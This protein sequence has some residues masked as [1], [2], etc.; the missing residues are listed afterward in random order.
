MPSLS[1]A[2]PVE[3]VRTGDEARVI[4][5]IDHLMPVL[6][7]WR[8]AEDL[9]NR[10]P[11]VERDL[12]ASHAK[13]NGD[14]QQVMA[15]RAEQQ[16]VFSKFGSFGNMPYAGM[17]AAIVLS[18]LYFAKPGNTILLIF[19][20]L[21]L[22]GGIAWGFFRA[23]GIQ[24]GFGAR[25]MALESEIAN[26]F[27]EIESLTKLKA[28]VE[29]GIEARSGG[30]PEV[31]VANVRFNLA[32]ATIDGRNVLLDT[33]GDT[34]PTV[35]RAVD[36]SSMQQG[37]SGI[38]AKAEAL[39]SVPPMLAPGQ[40][41]ES[42]D[43]V[44]QLF[45]EERELQDLVT[46]FTFGLGKLK[47]VSLSL[48]MLTADGLLVT[49]LASPDPQKAGIRSPEDGPAIEISKGSDMASQIQSFVQGVNQTKQ[50]GNQVFS[51]MQEVFR[52]LELACSIYANAR[53]TSVNTVHQNL[54]EVLNRATWCG[55]RFYCPRTILSP[56]YLQDILEIDPAKAFLLSL[57]DL[58]MRLRRDPEVKRRLD[59]SP[60]LEEQLTAA[61]D[62][63]QSFIGDD[64]FDEHGQRTS[65]HR[66]PK[67][68]ED[69][70]RESVKLFSSVLTRVMTGSSYPILNFSTE[71][72]VFY[73][74][75]ME[76]WRSDVVP[77]T[78][79]TP[80]IQKYGGV[81]KA[82]SDLLLPLWE[83][84]WT[85]KAD[86]RKAELF[87]TNESMIRM[88]EK[89]SEKLIDIGNQ[90]RGDM[91]TVREN[92]YLLESELQSKHSEI[93]AF[94][95]GMSQLGLLSDRVQAAVSD[96]KLKGMVVGEPVI[97]KM[98]QFESLLSTLPQSQAE[99]RGTAHDP[100]EVIREP[101]ALIETRENVGVRLLSL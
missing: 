43:A 12:A 37:L 54:T 57:D 29:T 30:F 31:K 13:M 41:Q 93:L 25:A 62:G 10:L 1:I 95:D 3:N 46:E 36:V 90:F 69:Q 9:R 34:P 16:L 65:A 59:E 2:R 68:L 66:R 22:V 72:Q 80:E 77:Y 11:Q 8:Q 50:Q 89:E 76:E 38:S 52:N 97:P 40:R 81:V 32:A 24:D 92:V 86:F 73:D 17:A 75:E 82:Y 70:F 64:T 4:A 18:A 83:H 6:A 15:V 14:K 27:T 47:D 85:E 55:R 63:V 23:K 88:T 99:N 21:A 101:G 5:L 42:V 49:R 60:D 35:L 19:G 61:Y 96:D 98:G 48:P 33:A 39:L 67:H 26:A 94:R 45:G 71:A 58:L 78:Y 74:P 51:E 44:D 84:L 79:T 100:I 56:Q 20:L 28:E 7:N 53:T 91:R 87:R